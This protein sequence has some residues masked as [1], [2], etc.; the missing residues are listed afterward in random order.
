M[1]PLL[2]ILLLISIVIPLCFSLN[3]QSP[4]LENASIKDRAVELANDPDTV[5]WMKDIRRKIHE[6]PELAFEEFETSKIIRHELDQLGIAYRWPVAKTGV[7]ATIGSGSPP[8]VA[9]RADMDALPIQELTEWE[10]KSKVDGKMHACG[11]D[12]HVAMLLGAAKILQELRHMLQ[13]TVVLIFQPAEEQG[14]GAKAM[15]EA[16]VLDNVEAIFGLHLVQKYPT[17]AV[18]SRPGEFLAGCGGFTAKISGKGGHAAV[19]QQSIDPIL[20]ASASVISLQQIV[21]RETD[22]LDSQVV[23]VAMINGGTAFNVIP[24]STTISGTFRAF[25]KKGFHALR[26]RIEEVIKGQA[27]VH[28]C[29]SEIDFTGNGNPTIPPT[30]NDVKIY[31]HV[32]RVSIDV[33]GEQNT[34]VAPAFMGSEDFAFYQEKV[35]GSFLFLGIRNEKLGCVHPPHSPYFTVDEDVFPI[36]AAVHAEFALSYLSDSL[37]KL[38]SL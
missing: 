13:G 28:R 3:L 35:P 34:Q 36:G 15:I 27:A 14:E 5:N 29:S 4:I 20:A 24:D 17:G 37:K 16:G 10:H 18:A 11:H 19:P 33:V 2:H 9:L 25:S 32:R 12:G 23:S 7:V 22:P 1:A 26:E 8:F 6:N 31:E 38:T 30:V 21:S